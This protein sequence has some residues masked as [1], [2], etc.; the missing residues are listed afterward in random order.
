MKLSARVM[1]GN[2]S[3]FQDGYYREWIVGGIF[4]S[5]VGLLKR[6]ISGASS[7]SVRKIYGIYILEQWTQYFGVSEMLQELKVSS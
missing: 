1:F 5:K 6:E 7:E 3:A 2:Y 4:N